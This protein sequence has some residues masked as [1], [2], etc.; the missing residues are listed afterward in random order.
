MRKILILT[1][2]FIIALFGCS[3][4]E[5]TKSTVNTTNNNDKKI[6]LK[7]A[8]TLSEDMNSI[9]VIK[10]LAK[11]VYDKTDGKVEIQIYADSSLGDQSDYFKG[12]QMGTVEM[13]LVAA[14]VPEYL[15]NHFSIFGCPGLFENAEEFNNFYQTD[16]AQEI[17]EN[18]RKNNHIRVIGV[19]H[20]GIRDIWVTDKEIH[21]V[22]DF[23]GLKLRVPDVAMSI[24]KFRALGVNTISMAL[25]DVYTGLQSGAIQGIE[26]N[27]E[28]IIGNNLQDLIKYRIKTNHTYSM[29]LFMVTENALNAMDIQ[30]KNIFIECVEK[31]NK[32]AFESYKISQQ[33]AYK[34]AEEA[35]IITIELNFEEK[36][37]MDEIWHSVTKETID[38]IFPETIYDV[39]ENCKQ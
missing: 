31:S 25:S 1:A 9:K 23:A 38:G 20:E 5:T 26:N 3:K 15:D 29:L 24:K 14:T 13:C 34:A 18:F 8:S 16:E 32:E 39:I 19:Y 27:V 6:I 37:K 11:N 12:I 10:N 35:G 21:S 33:E 7:F 28:I 4:N 22:D 36:R 17:F 30:T 2:I